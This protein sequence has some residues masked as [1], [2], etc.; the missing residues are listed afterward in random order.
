VTTYSAIDDTDID[1]ESPITTSLMTKL[2]DNPI[3][4]LEGDA[5]LPTNLRTR[6][7]LVYK[8]GTQNFARYNTVSGAYYTITFDAE[9]SDTSGFHSTSTNTDRLTVP[10]A[11]GVTKVQLI[12]QARF[13]VNSNGEYRGLTIAKNG[14]A[15][16]GMP[17]ITL[18]ASSYVAALPLA[19]S[20]NII[21]PVLDVSEG[22]YF[23]LVPDHNVG[24]LG[25]DIEGDA[26]GYNVWFSIQEVK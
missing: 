7:A 16:A 19:P 8:T 10:V 22:D 11:S 18:S 23:T 13:E 14:E 12:G 5:S 3:A 4:G 26:S 20:M 17:K 9:V 25:L 24:G 6:S 21:S 15:F 1:P 2:R